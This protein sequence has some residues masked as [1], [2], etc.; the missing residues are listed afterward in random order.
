MHM[1]DA[2][3]K[4]INELY[5]INKLMDQVAGV[6]V[7]PKGLAPANGLQGF[8]GGRNIIGNLSR[9]DFQAKGNTKLLKDCLLYTSRCV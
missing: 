2:I 1:I 8:F 4:G 6:E 5:W 3:W 9:V 7:N